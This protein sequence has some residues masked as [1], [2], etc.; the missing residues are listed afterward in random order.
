MPSGPMPSGESDS[1]I[2]G[3]FAS[4]DF[5][6]SFAEGLVIQDLQGR[7]IDANAAASVVLGVTR[8]QLLG[9]SSYDPQWRAVREDGTEFPGSEHPA[10][11]TLRTHEPCS[12]V[13]MGVD[14]PDHTRR[15]I[16]INANPL[17]VDGRLVA[18][19]TV[20]ADVTPSFNLEHELRLTAE[21]LKILAQHPADVVVLASKDAL[22]E[23]ASDSITELLGISPADVVGQRIDG[24]VHPDDLASIVDFRRLAPDAPSAQ[25]LVR[26]RRHDGDY[27]WVSISAR[28]FMDSVNNV[29]RIVSSWRDAQALVE[30]HA[31]LTEA[32]KRFRFL[33]EN[34][35][36]IVGETDA[37]Y[38]FTWMSPSVYDAL[39]WRPE[40]MI[41]QAA[42]DFI[43]PDDRPTFRYERASADTGL[44]RSAI[45]A[46]F[47]TSSGSVRWMTARAHPR[48]ND[49]GTPMSYVVALHDVHDEE[50][51]RR[52][53]EESESRY[54]LLADYGS[55]LVLLLDHDENYR[56]VSPSVTG[57]FGWLPQEM[58]GKNATH[59]VH[60]DDLARVVAYRRDHLHDNFGIDRFRWLRSDG[61]YAWVSGR[62]RDVRD[63]RGELDGRVIALRDISDQVAADQKLADSEALFR[64]VLDNQV[65][66]TARLGLD[67]TI[68]WISPSVFDLVGWRAE[69]ITGHRIGEFVHTADIPG[70]TLV[71]GNVIA[72]NPDSY[73]A[74]IHTLSGEDKWVAA[75]GKPLFDEF[76]ETTGSVINVRDVTAQHEVL[77]RLARSEEQFR[78]AMLS[79]PIG[80][81]LVDLQRRFQAVN[82]AMCEMVGRTSSWLLAHGVADV[83]SEED[84]Q[85]DL[86]MHAEA[87][88]GRII[89]AGREKRFLKP[90]ATVVWVEHAIGLVRDEAGLP[91]AFVSTFVDVTERRETQE[92][93]RYQATHDALTHLVNR[94]DLYLRAEKLQHH[95]MRTGEHVGVLYVDIDGFKKVNDS[96][97]HYVGDV[98][99]TI[100]AQR[101]AAVGRNEDVV[102]RVGGDEFVILLPSLHSVDD[103]RFVAQK[104]LDSFREPVVAEGA[105]IDIGV[106]IGVAMAQSGESPDDTLRR[107]DLALYQAKVRG[108]GQSVVWSD[109]FDTE[110]PDD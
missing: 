52:E 65:D 84:H 105:T 62:G 6:D 53:L 108:R 75:A 16:T 56:W 90:D 102:S 33:A 101:L 18:V 72:G 38:H 23:W 47:L 24:F 92:K 50:M 68:E 8:D 13:I 81:A 49:C 4:R 99:L 57:L 88:S 95:S 67:G 77:T 28:R 64:L 43:H 94:R 32:E 19:S 55:D 98:T 25:F 15:W 78:L 12:G 96:F 37:D 106:S 36:D 91:I 54:R 104:V 69:E 27:R 58:V 44:A 30:T 26:L 93:L 5:L 3:L 21:H 63:E 70:L 46:R 86:H 22:G 41:G 48:L 34:A 17:R 35:S 107:A 2:A 74:R 85:L 45:K 103:A 80:M 109:E 14:L 89:H 42:L 9:R 1:T 61:T 20:F 7:I 10:M 39:G 100:V 97:G 11:V 71:I 40:E 60:P 66:V 83:L 51:V 29:S 59:F 73:E 79:A 110:Q 87:L 82:P 76:G 31:K